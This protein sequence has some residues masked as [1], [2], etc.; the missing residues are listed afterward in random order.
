MFLVIS[1][2]LIGGAAAFFYLSSQDQIGGYLEPLAPV[3]KFIDDLIA[4]GDNGEPTTPEGP[5]PQT[6]FKPEVI[7]PTSSGGWVDKDIEKYEFSLSYPD[8]ATFIGPGVTN[9]D[10]DVYSVVFGGTN[11]KG[12]IVEDSDLNDGYIFRVSAFPNVQN[13]NL[14]NIAIQKRNSMLIK[15]PETARFS[16]IETTEI[17]GAETKYFD[18]TNCDQNY[19]YSF[20]IKGDTLY[21]LVQ[22]YKGDIGYDQF[23]RKTT[24]EIVDRF[25]FTNII[26]PSP[27]ETWAVFDSRRQSFLFRYP[28][29]LD[30]T[31]CTIDG[32]IS[33]TANKLIVLADG[34]SVITTKSRGYNGFGLF[35]DR[36]LDNLTF[37][38]YLEN[39]RR[40]LRENYKIVIGR[41]SP[42]TK[43]HIVSVGGVDGVLLEGYA[44]WGDILFIPIPD[45]KEIII[46]SVT[47]VNDGEMDSLFNEIL[48][49]FRLK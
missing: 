17:V 34:D 30:S 27:K 36:N 33:S 9:Q 8:S 41:A 10:V 42:E 23:Y 1:V 39:Q 25:K 43:E 3:F 28:K 18:I 37:E 29:E 32:P 21:E 5:E 22:I 48:S 44:W 40:L 16:N 24:D 26:A 19:I 46:F 11:Q 4:G 13:K 49:T 47:E 14:N 15:C 6:P 31:C 7:P 38:E 12:Q 2:L 35:E 45:S 20:V